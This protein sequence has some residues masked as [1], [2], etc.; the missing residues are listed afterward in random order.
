M[1]N[2]IKND[3]DR[4]LAGFLDHAVS[5][6]SPAKCADPLYRCIKD[7]VLRDG[8]RVRPILF[9]LS[10]TGYTRGEIKDMDPVYRA[11]LSLELLHDFLLV[12]DDIIDRSPM[13][14]GGPSMHRLFNAFYGKP[15]DSPSGGDLAIIAGDIIFA[16]AVETLLSIE[17]DANRKEKA[18]RIFLESTVDTGVGEYIDTVSGLSGI[19]RTPLEEVLLTYEYK[20]SKYTFR[21]PL[22][23]G[24]VLAGAG[25]TELEKLSALS[26][27]LGQAFQIQDDL[28]DV[29]SSPERTGKPV[30]SDIAEG[31][32]TL[33]MW[34]AF[35]ELDGPGRKEL[36]GLLKSG[37]K[38]GADI[39]RTAA[40]VRDTEAGSRCFS[41]MNGLFE[42]TLSLCGNLRMNTKQLDALETFIR[43]LVKRN[44]LIDL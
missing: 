21:C 29:F 16:F 4:A 24:A 38:T 35:S 34:H 19:E 1:L 5:R 32:R 36:T 40:I 22:N 20:T 3:L 11:S 41:R 37:T 9:I 15:A 28:L 39:E 17:E 14:R 2:A 43:S 27:S 7:F 13:R 31:K 23:M 12:H 44:D 33:L 8:K 18:L 6:I 26:S 42:D 25:S 30:L 10:Y